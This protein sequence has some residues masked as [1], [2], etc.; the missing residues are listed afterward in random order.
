[1]SV[2]GTERGRTRGSEAPGR[3]RTVTS[4]PIQSD[5][6]E[7]IDSWPVPNCAAGWTNITGNL[8]KRGDAE[9]V[10]PIA[11]LTKPLVALAIL[12]AVEEGSLGLDT[13]AGPPGSTI[14]HLLAHASGLGPEDSNPVAAPGS[15]RIYSNS[16]YEALGHALETATDMSV[17]TYFDEAVSQPL[18]L[19][20][21]KILG[22]PAHGAVSTVT[23]LL[24]V[25]AELLA[26]T[27]LAPETMSAAT[28]V[29]FSELD[30]VLPGYGRQSPNQWGLGF[31]I[32]GNKHPHWT[33]A[34]NSPAT[35]GHFGRSG[36]MIW[37]DPSLGV[38]CVALTDREFG[39][40]AVE[41]WPALGA[42]IIENSTFVA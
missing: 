3:V 5:P 40:W 42:A 15:R 11:S 34:T 10:F 35:F 39:P 37:I 9:K 38:G 20:A 22:S 29:Q 14:R 19:R 8:S 1:M 4:S 25:V 33:A 31:E 24:G 13:H 23:D 12:V 41:S 16:G 6:L 36:T 18:G 2:Q 28:T 27:I 17:S 7:L 21:T 30:G 32:R 26:P